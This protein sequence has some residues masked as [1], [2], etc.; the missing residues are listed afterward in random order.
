MHP[1]YCAVQRKL[2]PS[3]TLHHPLASP[4]MT[5]GPTHTG[6]HIM[7]VWIPYIPPLLTSTPADSPQ[8]ETVSGDDVK[9]N[10]LSSGYL[11][12]LPY[13]PEYVC[14]VVCEQSLYV[15]LSPP[16][17]SAPTDT[18]ECKDGNPCTDNQECLNTVSSYVC[19]CKSGYQSNG[20][21]C[22]GEWKCGQCESGTCN[23][24]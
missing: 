5:S 16:L 21:T 15:V 13:D 20:T 17:P 22:E 12:M 23:A 6:G 19:R 18:D 1:P 10:I 8:S 24:V 2:T 7:C 3:P 4:L 14:V 9:D 11:P